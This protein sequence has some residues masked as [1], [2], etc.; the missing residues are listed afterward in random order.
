MANMQDQLVK[1]LLTR[2]K[3]GDIEV[4]LCRRNFPYILKSPQ[5]DPQWEGLKIVTRNGQ[6]TTEVDPNYCLKIEID[7]TCKIHKTAA[8]IRKLDRISKETVT[9]RVTKK[10]DQTSGEMVESKEVVAVVPEYERL[11][12]S[13][14][15]EDLVQRIA[16]EVA[17]LQNKPPKEELETVD[18]A[19][20][21]GAPRRGRPPKVPISA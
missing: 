7:G 9:T 13:V 20:Q 11:Q 6:R 14:I 8:N 15:E 3:A 16:A 1:E 10:F 12:K 4:I 21:T 2:P 19:A 17:K 5:W 18:G